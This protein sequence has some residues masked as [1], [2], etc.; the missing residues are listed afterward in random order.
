[1]NFLASLGA[2][3]VSGI[4]T[5]ILIFLSTAIFNKIVL[6]WYRDVVYKGVNLSGEWS[7]SDDTSS[8]LSVHLKQVGHQL[9]GIAAITIEPVENAIENA[10]DGTSAKRVSNLRF[11]GSTH[12]GYLVGHFKSTDRREVVFANVLLKVTH[13][14]RRLRGVMTFREAST[15]EIVTQKTEWSR[16]S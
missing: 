1:M 4:I 12:D 16:Q 9:N 2:G 13:A 10:V 3:V 11:E 15:D 7:E 14:G 6:P 8:K 5:A